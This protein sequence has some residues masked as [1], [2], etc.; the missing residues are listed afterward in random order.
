MAPRT[1]D[2]PHPARLAPTRVECFAIGALPDDSEKREIWIQIAK[3]GEWFRAGRKIAL[4]A[5]DLVSMVERFNATKNDLVCDYEHTS[6]RPVSKSK[7]AGWISRLETRDEG[8]TL[9]ALTKFTKT[10]AD[11]IRADEYRFTSPAFVK[12][13]EDPHTGATVQC[14]LTSVALTNTPFLDGMARVQLSRAEGAEKMAADMDP[15]MAKLMELTGA[16]DADALI[17]WVEAKAKAPEAEM[18]KTPD[19]ESEKMKRELATKGDALSVAMS[20]LAS[21]EPRLAELEK[22]RIDGLVSSVIRAGKATEAEREALS[23]IAVSDRAAFD[24]LTASRVVVPVGGQTKGPEA[25]AQ[26]SAPQGP[27]PEFVAMA[28]GAGLNEAAIKAAWA[29]RAPKKAEV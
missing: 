19:E 16:A 12:H 5:A 10:A 4:T 2:H 11:E 9:W 6:E 25:D 24:A 15:T 13:G 22:E 21:V 7:A 23:R 8:T 18:T 1:T 20:R 27:T 3:T 29:K 14:E 26:K 17:A 28:R